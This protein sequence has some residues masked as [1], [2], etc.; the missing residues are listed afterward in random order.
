MQGYPLQV[1]RGPLTIRIPW[2]VLIGVHPVEEFLRDLIAIDSM[3]HKLAQVIGLLD[4]R[5]ISD[6]IGSDPERRGTQVEGDVLCLNPWDPLSH[7]PRHSTECLK[8]PEGNLV[9]DVKRAGDQRRLHRSRIANDLEDNRIDSLG[10]NA[11]CPVVVEPLQGDVGTADPVH[12]LERA[13]PDR[14]TAKIGPCESSYTLLLRA[15][16]VRPLW[17]DP[18]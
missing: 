11:R 6:L 17:H 16:S 8:I 12:K 10:R 13:G 4:R 18:V 3:E 9:H 2:T 1:G 15:L 5:F 7:D 14:V